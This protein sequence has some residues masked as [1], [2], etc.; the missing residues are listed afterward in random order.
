MGRVS[1][2]W[3]D[4]LPWRTSGDTVSLE[5]GSGD[6]TLLPALCRPYLPCGRLTQS[7][8]PPLRTH[9]PQDSPQPCLPL[10]KKRHSPLRT[11]RV[12]GS[13]ELEQLNAEMGLGPETC[14]A[15]PLMLPPLPPLGPDTPSLVQSD[16]E[17]QAVAGPA[18]LGER[19][20]G[21]V[22]LPG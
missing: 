16:Q 14:P 4:A 20:A 6:L 9:L 17:D 18:S 5:A 8:S 2:R 15:E 3:S 11:S 1:H 19:V 21:T 7:P 22:G 12:A 13:G 10:R